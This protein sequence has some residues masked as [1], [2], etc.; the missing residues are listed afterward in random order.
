[1]LTL[2]FKIDSNFDIDFNDIRDSC[3]EGN[4]EKLNKSL[5]NIIFQNEDSYLYLN[6]LNLRVQKLL[7]ILNQYKKHK[8]IDLALDNLSSKVFWKD[9]PIIKKQLRLWNI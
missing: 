4:K 7:E 6:N 5:G 9:K 8:N 3:F 2:G 1:M